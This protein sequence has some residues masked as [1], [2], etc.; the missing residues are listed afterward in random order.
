MIRKLFSSRVRRSFSVGGF[1]LISISLLSCQQSVSDKKTDAEVK[2]D[3]TNALKL[4]SAVQI[5]ISTNDIA[6]SQSFYEKLGFKKVADVGPSIQM[7]DESI[8]IMLQPNKEHYVRI[9]Y[10]S[11]DADKLVD[12]LEKRGIVFKTKNEDMGM[13]TRSIFSAPDNIEVSLVKMDPS[14]VYKSSGKSWGQ[15]SETERKNVDGYPNKICGAFGEFCFPVKNCDSSF[16]FWKQLGFKGDKYTQPYPWAS[17]TDGIFNIGLHQQTYFNY[18][19]LT[20]V[21]PDMA[22]RIAKLQKQGLKTTDFMGDKNNVIVETP[23]GF[24]IFLFQG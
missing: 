5:T 21:A 13:Y 14:G 12:Q 22:Q 11:N 2:K 4:G 10:F 23:E 7:C 17:V 19:A 18:P 24:H 1:L 15:M 3:S 8:L 6:K 9:S 20:L 16:A